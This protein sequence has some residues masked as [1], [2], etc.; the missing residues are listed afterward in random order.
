MARPAEKTYASVNCADDEARRQ[1]FV[2]K[3]SKVM[4]SQCALCVEPFPRSSGNPL[5]LTR[6]WHPIFLGKAGRKARD[7][8]ASIK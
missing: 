4:L 3:E 5:I 8:L 6:G 1:H 7:S 2:R